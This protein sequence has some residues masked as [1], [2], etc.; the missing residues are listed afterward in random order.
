[1]LPVGLDADIY[2]GSLHFG[3]Y[4]QGHVAC[5]ELLRVLEADRRLFRVLEADRRCLRVLEAEE[6]EERGI[7]LTMNKFGG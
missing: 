3:Q 2:P 4:P 5:G 6:E 1:V 7:L